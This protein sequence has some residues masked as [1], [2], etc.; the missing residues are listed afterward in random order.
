MEFPVMDES[1]ALTILAALADGVNPLTGEVFP[2]DSP[3][4]SAEIVRALYC[5]AR[6]LDAGKRRTP[7]AGM[8]RNAGKPWSEE[9]DRRL[10]EAFD[11]G[12]ALE[13]LAQNHART[14]AGIQ[15]RLER[16]GRLQLQPL[17]MPARHP[18][19]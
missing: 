6:V 11:H 13:A 16:H 2:A 19:A 18:H 4:Q 7:R 10:L 1:K 12:E 15:A 3:Y 9:E 17:G 5:A 14:R 8:P